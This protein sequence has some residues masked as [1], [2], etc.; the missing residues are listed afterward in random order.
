MIEFL[1]ALN[2]N[3]A[4]STFVLNNIILLYLIKHIITYICKKTP[5]AVDDDLPSFFGGMINLVN[6]KGDKK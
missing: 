5:W 1:I 2:T 4:I 6:T 3:A